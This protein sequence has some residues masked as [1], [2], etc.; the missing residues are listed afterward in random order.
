VERAV[1]SVAN[2]IKLLAII[3]RNENN[4]ELR[5]NLIMITHLKGLIAAPH[6]PMFADGE[7]NLSMIER[8]AEHFIKNDVRAVYVCG[9]T[10]EGM[11]LTI[12]ERI[13]IAQH[14]QDVAKSD[15][16]VL[17][18]VGHTCLKDCRTLAVHAAK[19]GVYGI[20]AMPP[21]YYKPATVNDLMEFYA[22]IA[23]AASSL[24]FYA[25]HTPGLTG[26]NFKMSHFLE[27]ASKCIPSLVGIKFNHIDLM[28]Y[29][30]CRAFENGRYDILYGVDE[31]LLASLPYGTIGAIGSTYNYAAPLYYDLIKAYNT[32]EFA[33]AQQFQNRSIEIIQKLLKYNVLAAGKS[34]M[35]MIGIDCGPVR[36][37]VRNMTNQELDQLGC[38][39][40]SIGF[41][42]IIDKSRRLL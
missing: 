2:A 6:T 7:V 26:V 13:S 16:K 12:E 29:A 4:K 32:G 18:N 24:P 35:K 8:Q 3:R 11:S 33:R 1:S 10:G 40:R 30:Q 19:A 25:Y 15:I 20:S 31:M 22:E 21:F 9:T 17:V 34:I 23:K 36:L 37:P 41:F 27:V 39:L 42:D 38:D 28:D 5:K 14:W